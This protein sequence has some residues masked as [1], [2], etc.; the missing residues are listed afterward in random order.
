M[1][2]RLNP[3]SGPWKKKYDPLGVKFLHDAGVDPVTGFQTTWEKSVSDNA[4]IITRFD[5]EPNGQIERWVMDGKNVT[6][7]H[8]IFTIKDE[9]ERHQYMQLGYAEDRFQSFS[10]STALE[11]AQRPRF[12]NITRVDAVYAADGAMSSLRIYVGSQSSFNEDELKERPV[13]EN[14]IELAEI[15]K[16]SGEKAASP[17]VADADGKTEGSWVDIHEAL[18][19]AFIKG[20][21]M[22]WSETE[23]A[24]I[25]EDLTAIPQV[26]AGVCGDKMTPEQ[27]SSMASFLS[28]ETVK[29][30]PENYPKLEGE[31]RDSAFDEAFEEAILQSFRFHDHSIRE[32]AR[33]TVMFAPNP[34]EKDRYLFVVFRGHPLNPLSSD[35][36]TQILATSVTEVGYAC[37]YEDK[38]FG[39]IRSEDYFAV[40]ISSHFNR[41]HKILY[42]APEKLSMDKLLPIIKTNHSSEWQNAFEVA[43]VYLQVI[44]AEDQEKT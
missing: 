15:F 36:P 3:P 33:H 21:L 26:I 28:A 44:P 11:E 19:G 23:K 42:L 37:S 1:S 7:R 9:G 25:D 14:I 40:L 4:E 6:G 39:L 35:E 8:I 17:L 34:A 10:I 12:L 20:R 18:V 29:A 24:G 32:L 2:E 27:I 22:Q 5:K 43:R 16:S 13:E 38:Q 31:E 30:L 41:N